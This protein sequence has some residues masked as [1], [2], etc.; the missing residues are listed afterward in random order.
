MG[1]NKSKAAKEPEKKQETQ[2]GD[3]AAQEVKADGIG[4]PKAP[5]AQAQAGTSTRTSTD[6]ST[7][8]G[9]GT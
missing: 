1:S 5:E 4:T 7:G 6:T 9:T 8:T 3:V 2:K